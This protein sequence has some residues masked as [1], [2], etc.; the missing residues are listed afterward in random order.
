MKNVQPFQTYE[1]G[2]TSVIF[3]RQKGNRSKV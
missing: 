2:Q 3:S 1:F